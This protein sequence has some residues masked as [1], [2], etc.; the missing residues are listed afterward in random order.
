MSPTLGHEYL[1]EFVR[2]RPSLVTTLLA[3]VGIAVP[4]FDQAR[5]GTCDFT[6]C[7]SALSSARRSA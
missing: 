4:S 7:Q 1:I 3:E 5:L 6:D 2:N